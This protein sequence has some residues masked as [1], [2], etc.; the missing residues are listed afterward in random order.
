M[1]VK[2]KED[3]SND[4]KQENPIVRIQ[5]GAS[6]VDAHFEIKG[7]CHSFDRDRLKC[8]VG[9]VSRIVLRKFS[10]CKSIG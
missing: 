8:H 7:L 3:T 9:N 4:R 10:L 1:V 5:N 6:S 2:I